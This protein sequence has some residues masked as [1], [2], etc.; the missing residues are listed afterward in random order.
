MSEWYATQFDEVPEWTQ[1]MLVLP[2]ILCVDFRVWVTNARRT[3]S[4]SSQV[5]VGLD[6]ELVHLSVGAKMP[7]HTL[8]PIGRVAQAQVMRLIGQNIEPFAQDRPG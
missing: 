3:W 4:T 6:H 5:T 2:D 7:L 1:G 8:D